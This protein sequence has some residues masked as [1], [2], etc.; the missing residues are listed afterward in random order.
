MTIPF[1]LHTTLT[2]TNVS[3]LDITN[4]FTIQTKSEQI[5]KLKNTDGNVALSFSGIVNPLGIIFISTSSFDLHLTKGAVT[6]DL[7][8][9]NGIPFILPIDTTTL[10]Q[11][12]TITIS[13]TSTSDILV[14]IQA[15]GIAPT[16]T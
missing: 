14:Q 7:A 11:F 6:V 5:L 1:T 4:T 16:A 3:D 2:G 9:K 12:T 15:Y 13:T 10:A 8:I